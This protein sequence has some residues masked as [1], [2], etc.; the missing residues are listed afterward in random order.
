MTDHKLAA[1]AMTAFVAIAA[2]TGGATLAVFTDEEDV[3]VQFDAS[4]AGNTG[5]SQVAGATD[6]A[7]TATDTTATDT[8]A[9]DEPATD[10]TTEDTTTEPTTTQEPTTTTASTTSVE[11]T[12][13]TAGNTQ[14]SESAVVL[15]APAAIELRAKTRSVEAV[16]M[17]REDDPSVGSDAGGSP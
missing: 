8:T 17:N 6:A 12:T 5:T 16:E 15:L 3:S 14:T 11:G 4:V 10:T 9:T 7:S 1:L 2:L 13:T